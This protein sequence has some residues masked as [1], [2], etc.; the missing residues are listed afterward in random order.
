M[1]EG[2]V[3]VNTYKVANTYTYLNFTGF[4][5]AC[6]ISLQSQYQRSQHHSLRVNTQLHTPYD[7]NLEWYVTTTNLHS[8]DLVTLLANLSD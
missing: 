4:H 5:I 1:A 3:N 7:E 8:P 2:M 6:M